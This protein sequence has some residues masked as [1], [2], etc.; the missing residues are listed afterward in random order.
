MIAGDSHYDQ[1]IKAANELGN[2]LLAGLVIDGITE[3]KK[4]I[5]ITS[6]LWNLNEIIRNYKIEVDKLK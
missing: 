1:Q 6:S 5:K 2:A 4:N 3:N